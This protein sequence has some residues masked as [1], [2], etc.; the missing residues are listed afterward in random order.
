MRTLASTAIL[1]AFA[2]TIAGAQTIPPAP[3][4]QPAPKSMP[5]AAPA[6]TSA[7]QMLTS[8]PANAT[9]ITH[10][11]KQPV[12]DQSNNR[13]GEI[14]DVLVDSEARIVALVIGVGGFL[15]IGERHV[16]VPYNAVRVTTRDGNKWH[17]VMNSTKEALNSASAFKY[18]RSTMVWMPET[19]A[20]TGRATPS[21]R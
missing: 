9:T 2:T 11:H 21:V 1:L 15:G 4:S 14:D 7:V 20:T 3:P 17:L 10:W 5:Q 19:P 12:Y 8:I 18:D 13:I 16:A 6:A